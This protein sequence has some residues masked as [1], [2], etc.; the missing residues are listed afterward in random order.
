[1]YKYVS[2]SIKPYMRMTDTKFMIVAPGR[3]S[4][5]RNGLHMGH[6]RP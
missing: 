4:D 2:K 5:M 1:M 6:M 3:R